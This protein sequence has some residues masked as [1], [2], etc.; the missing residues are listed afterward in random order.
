MLLTVF[1]HFLPESSSYLLENDDSR[2]L[3]G[4]C[5]LWDDASMDLVFSSAINSKKENVSGIW[6]IRRLAWTDWGCSVCLMETERQTII[7]EEFIVGMV[8]VITESVF[9]LIF[10]SIYKTLT[11]AAAPNRCIWPLRVA[12]FVPH[13]FPHPLVRWSVVQLMFELT[14]WNMRLVQVHNSTFF[15]IDYVSDVQDINSSMGGHFID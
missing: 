2:R 8:V 14:E 9:F 13:S 12:F 1:I 6:E 4:T 5:E 15:L 7:R 10:C 3:L 11:R